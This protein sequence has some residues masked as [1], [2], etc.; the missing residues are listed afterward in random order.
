MDKQKE[1][2]EIQDWVR[3]H[4]AIEREEECADK[5]SSFV[6]KSFYPG[7]Y[8]DDRCYECLSEYI[9]YIRIDDDKFFVLIAHTSDQCPWGGETFKTKEEDMEYLKIQDKYQP[10]TKE[11][12][13]KTKLE[14][15][16]REKKIIETEIME[17]QEKLLKISKMEEDHIAEFK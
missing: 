11:Y 4:L 2:K 12:F 3:Q 13:Y 10:I 15:I 17:K 6:L 1:L 8:F 9:V 7:K 14:I 5:H 16:Q